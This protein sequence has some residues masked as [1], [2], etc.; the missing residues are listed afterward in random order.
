[1]SAIR[2]EFLKVRRADM[3]RF[4]W[5]GAHILALIEYV[6]RLPGERNGRVS[7]DGET[8]WQA[9]YADLAESIGNTTRNSVWRK[10]GELGSAG[11]LRS[12]TP[13]C[14]KGSSKADTTKAYRVAPQRCDVSFHSCETESPVVSPQRDDPVSHRDDPVSAEG[15]LPL[16][17]ELEEGGE[18]ALGSVPDLVTP[19]ICSDHPNGNSTTRCRVCATVREW[20]E[21]AEARSTAAAQQEAQDRKDAIEACPLCDQNGL[22]DSGRSSSVVRCDHE[23][24]DYIEAGAQP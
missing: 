12:C 23:Q 21:A 2:P 20:H 14:A 6:Q 16:L 9:S 15:N 24:P 13:G 8:W 22:R 11:V 17:G 7:I 10:V 5:L 3:D 18:K 4:G 1:M 19:P